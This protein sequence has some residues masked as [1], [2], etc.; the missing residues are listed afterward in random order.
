[1]AYFSNLDL[2]RVEDD[3]DRS[4]PAS[5]MLLL[6]R[7]D[8]LKMRLEELEEKG[9]EKE[10]LEGKEHSWELPHKKPMNNLKYILPEHL[11]CIRDVLAALDLAVDELALY[12][13]AN[14]VKIELQ[15]ERYSEVI[16]GQINIDDYL[17]YL[18]TEGKSTSVMITESSKQ[19]AA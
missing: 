15:E 10:G 3:Y 11:Y 16:P 17:L 14:V 2:Y 5:R 1:M 8:D 13:E 7:I 19:K 18:K 4:C 6:C 12:D 9:K